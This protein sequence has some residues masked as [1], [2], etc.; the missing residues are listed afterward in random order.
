MRN[1]FLQFCVPSLVP[2]MKS[3][4]GLEKLKLSVAFFLEYTVNYLD[5]FEFICAATKNDDE[6][7]IRTWPEISLEC[8]LNS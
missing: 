8:N 2:V 3:V 5:M 7:L 1:T 6:P 4:F